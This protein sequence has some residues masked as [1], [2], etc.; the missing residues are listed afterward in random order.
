MVRSLCPWQG[1]THVHEA[2]GVS[3]DGVGRET[4]RP[5][6]VGGTGPRAV[7][8]LSPETECVTLTAKGN[9]GG[10]APA[11]KIGR[12][13]RSSN[14]ECSGA[15]HWRSINVRKKQHLPNAPARCCFEC[16]SGHVRR[17]VGASRTWEKWS[18]QEE[19]ACPRLDL[20][21]VSPVQDL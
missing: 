9:S 1:Q 8:I 16:R 2:L 14:P 3:Q 21:P 4:E 17:S 10:P 11:S 5:S 7:H 19:P 15:L 12:I 18:C 6:V 20:S 13:P